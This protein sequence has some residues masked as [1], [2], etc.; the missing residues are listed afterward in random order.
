MY[1]Q[2]QWDCQ[3]QKRNRVLTCHLLCGKYSAV[4]PHLFASP[5]T[6]SPK[7]ESKGISSGDTFTQ[8]PMI[9]DLWPFFII[10]ADANG[11]HAT[12]L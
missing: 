1:T 3:Y 11:R 8:V 7:I 12:Q 6:Y 9:Q 5:Q 2:T 10:Y 4:A